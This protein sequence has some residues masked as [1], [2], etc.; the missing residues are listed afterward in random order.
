MTHAKYILPDGRPIIAIVPGTAVPKPTI[1]LELTPD[2]T[3]WSQ[4]QQILGTTRRFV[5]AK[6]ATGL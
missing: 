3:L 1:T 5:R 4:G 6:R 2:D